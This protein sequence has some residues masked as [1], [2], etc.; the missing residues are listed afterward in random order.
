MEEKIIIK[1]EGHLND[2]RKDWFDG[3]ELCYDGNI[4]VLTGNNKDEAYVHGILNQILDLILKLISVN[5]NL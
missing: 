4:T 5:Q 2:N 3:L 1:I